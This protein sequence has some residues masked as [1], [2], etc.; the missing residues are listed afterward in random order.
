M[1]MDKNVIPLVEY[2]NSQGLK[3]F[4]S[5]EGH[6]KTNIS[7]FWISFSNNVQEEDIINF[8][9]KHLNK[10]YGTFSSCGRFAQRVYIG[11]PTIIKEWCYFAAT[12]EAAYQDL[13]WWKE[14]DNYVS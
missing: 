1:N 3:T 4:M 5:C 7:M 9:K 12:I 8:Q 11:G 6:N 10:K 14:D 13:K 2:F